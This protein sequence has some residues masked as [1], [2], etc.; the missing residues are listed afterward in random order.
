M[1]D[2]EFSSYLDNK[3]LTCLQPR[4]KGAD[5]NNRV[6]LVNLNVIENCNFDN[7][8]KKT[9]FATFKLL[10]PE[11][12]HD[13]SGKT[14]SAVKSQ[15]VMMSAARLSAVKCHVD[16]CKT[17]MMVDAR[18]SAVKCHDDRCKTVSC[19]MSCW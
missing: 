13:D 17:V 9:N 5:T 7:R 2:L 18:L 12:C 3:G 16:R 1:A 6:F 4:L 15:N 11:K 19:E 8:L 10:V 14:D